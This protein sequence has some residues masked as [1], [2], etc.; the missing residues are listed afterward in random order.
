MHL[1]ST[2]MITVFQREKSEAARELTGCERERWE[3]GWTKVA[4][5]KRCL[6]FLRWNRLSLLSSP[7]L[8]WP[9]FLKKKTRA[10]GGNSWERWRGEKREHAQARDTLSSPFLTSLWW[11]LNTD[12]ETSTRRHWF[13]TEDVT[14]TFSDLAYATTQR[15]FTAQQRHS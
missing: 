6:S 2:F 3:R 12:L 5:D 8:T 7:L 4:T 9:Q 10:S 15:L 13:Y 1:Y 11:L 14:V